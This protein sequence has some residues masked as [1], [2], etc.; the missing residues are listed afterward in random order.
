[1]LFS[2]DCW[3]TSRLR[4]RDWLDGE[5]RQEVEVEAGE[6]K[7]EGEEHGEGAI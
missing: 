7:A 5:A 2:D 4:V 3:C 1:M 6:D